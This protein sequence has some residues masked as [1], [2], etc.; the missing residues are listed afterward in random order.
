VGPQSSMFSAYARRRSSIST[1]P[2]FRVEMDC[3]ARR[4]SFSPMTTRPAAPDGAPRQ[5]RRD[6]S[7]ATGFLAHPPPGFHMELFVVSYR[8]APQRLRPRCH[9][10]S[11]PGFLIRHRWRTQAPVPSA[12]E[13]RC[14]HY[15]SACRL[16]HALT[17]RAARLSTGCARTPHSTASQVRLDTRFRTTLRTGDNSSPRQG[18]TLADRIARPPREHCGSPFHRPAP[19]PDRRHEDRPA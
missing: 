14:A 12:R 15:F 11:P 2:W 1:S 9:R 4:S 7:A 16:S 8:A 13:C 3:G 6:T 17:R 5:T 10:D 18:R 19:L